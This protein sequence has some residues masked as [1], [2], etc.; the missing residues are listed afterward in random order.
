V[1]ADEQRAVGYLR[2]A[3]VELNETRR[4]LQEAED[5]RSEPIAIVGMGCRYPGGVKSPDDL[6]ELVSAERE[7]V[8]DLPGDRDWDLASLYDS[9]PTDRRYAYK[10]GFVR[11]ADFDAG[12]FGVSEQEALMMDPQQR[13]LLETTW[14]ACENTGTDPTAL[15][16]S[17]TGVFIGLSVQSYGSW[18]VG[19]VSE[20]PEG[21]LTSGNSGSMASGRLAHMLALEGPAVTVDTACSSSGMALHLA[22]QSL[23]LRE[24]SLAIAGGATI[25]STPWMYIEFGRQSQFPLSSDGRCKSFA[26]EAD[27]AAFSEGV[28][29]V[30]LERLSDARRLGHDVLAVVRGSAANQDGVSNGL[31]APNGLAHEQVIRQAL[32]DAGVSPNQV[33][34]VEGHGMGT[35]LGDPIEAQA[36]LAAYGRDRDIDRPL[37][38]GS[39]KSN[40][41]HTQ[42]ASTM[43]GV[44]KMVMAMRHRRLPK[45]LHVD[46]PSRHV[47]WSS[48]SV[49]LLV[50]SMPWAQTGDVRR[51]AVHA[52]GVS[53]T[54]VHIILEE[55]PQT[56]ASTESMP[57]RP[58]PRPRAV[59]GIGTVMPWI[60]SGRGDKGLRLQAQRL[61]EFI[62]EHPYLDVADVGYSLAVSRAEMTHRAVVIGADREQ[63]TEGLREVAQ[64]RDGRSAVE[65]VVAQGRSDVA[66]VVAGGGAGWIDIAATLV[67]SSPLFSAEITRM[68]EALSDI[69]KWSLRDLLHSGLSAVED[70]GALDLVDF[71]VAASLF[72]FWQRCG[73]RPSAIVGHG[74][75]EIVAAY[76]A[77][78]LTLEHAFRLVI[79]HST[80][81][82]TEITPLS[83][84]IPLWST[85]TGEL[86]DTTQPDGGHWAR[87]VSQQ[88]KLDDVI[89]IL[90]AQGYRALVEVSHTP[91]VSPAQR[92]EAL[93]APAI[94]GTQGGS[95]DIFTSIAEMWVKGITVDW[96]AL[97]TQ[98]DA[99]RVKLP[100][101]AFDSRRYWPGRTA[102][103]ESNGPLGQEHQSEAIL[104]PETVTQIGAG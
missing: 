84:N 4:R 91:V 93:I 29:V 71:S 52:L 92:R 48:G 40:I 104:S 26:D 97:F 17:C 77:G 30:V 102:I 15:R 54:N 80:N 6:W 67:E 65:G 103:W 55:P 74:A 59:P 1:S 43:A 45:T 79:S 19:S 42:A 69:A 27:G 46:T 50:E 57:P 2:R 88:S 81:A 35:A 33:D 60:V 87:T 9:A 76:V 36:L 73:V 14:E 44:I 62:V 32:A 68:D 24:C 90:L 22:C 72:G 75:G 82:P 56:E 58:R 20:C 11:A 23:R 64:C 18:L 61:A 53:G 66:F 98:V 10:G 86:V 49:A 99:Q 89:Q 31:T 28:G 41:G 94:F 38:L 83:P 39:I 78:A 12:F 63:L 70:R 8:S 51:A 5:R 21:Y 37:W 95:R 3:L 85:S 96:R 34:A 16:G 100:T 101:Y 7:G 47:D 13:L 25:M